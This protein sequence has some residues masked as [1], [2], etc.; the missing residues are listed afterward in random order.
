MNV[1]YQREASRALG[2]GSESLSGRNKELTGLARMYLQ[3]PSLEYMAK[4]LGKRGDHDY[5]GGTHS[6][7][8]SNYIYFS[9]KS[10]F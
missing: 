10:G 5:I 2:K 9:M 1:D 4:V 3:L 8:H 7:A 6:S